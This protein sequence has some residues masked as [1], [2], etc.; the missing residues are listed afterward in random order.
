MAGKKK[1]SGTSK[2]S[3]KKPKINPDDVGV[4]KEEADEIIAELDNITQEEVDRQA[5]E[6]EK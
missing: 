1:A 6:A 5:R 4:S 3:T 2:K